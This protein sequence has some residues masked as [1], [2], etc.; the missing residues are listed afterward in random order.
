MLTLAAFLVP[1]AA[2]GQERPSFVTYN[3]HME[4]PGALEVGLN[5][6]FGTQRGGGSFLGAWIEL[7]YGVK[8]WWTME[9]YLD[10]QTRRPLVLEHKV[11]PVLYLEY[12]SLNEAD[13]TM[14]EVVGHD[15]EAEHA[16]PLDV[17]RHEHEHELEAKLILSSSVKG[18]NLAH[19]W[20]AE[21]NL[22]GGAWEF[23][24]AV[25]ATRPFT[26]AATSRPCRFCAE[27]F[28]GG[29]EVYGGLGDTDSFGFKGTS[30]YVAPFVSWE[31]P[32]GTTLRLSPTFGLNGK[33]HR[34]LLRFG[35]AREVALGRGRR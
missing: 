33:S 11:N 21:K 20:I 19:N 25:A 27:N 5:P 1:L 35:I 15:V 14:R 13:K 9:V 22:G 4:E 6:L 28:A 18:W 24:Y 7:E 8:G 26:L 12:A 29:V 3:H 34:F 16:E 10:G 30:H 17:T 2:H 23:G 32:G 31:L